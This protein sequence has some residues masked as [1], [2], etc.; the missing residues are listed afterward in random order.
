MR[1]ILVPDGLP[2][3]LRYRLDAAAATVGNTGYYARPLDLTDTTGALAA[4]P[5]RSANLEITTRC[6]LRCAHC[7]RPP[8]GEDMPLSRVQE[9]LTV[10]Q[11]AG[12]QELG[13]Q[14]LGEPLLHPDFPAILGVACRQFRVTLISNGLPLAPAVNSIILAAQPQRVTVSLDASHRAAAGAEAEERVLAMVRRLRRERDLRGLDGPAV[15][16]QAVADA[17]LVADTAR[18]ADWRA[19]ADAVALCSRVWPD[20]PVAVP[21]DEPCPVA[22]RHLVVRV[23]GRMHVCCADAAG[24]LTVGNLFTEGV[25]AAWQGKHAWHVRRRLLARDWPAPCR[26]CVL[27]SPAAR[28]AFAGLVGRLP[29]T[30]AEDAVL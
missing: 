10:L 23:D 29:G 11:A 19:A 22:F 20:L 26:D 2:E 16:I 25:E 7:P 1:Y 30:V 6:Q 28:R 24:E 9:A 8:G 4:L 3:A 5:P 21:A 17:S 14:H 15:A 27:R 12:V 18:L 13:L